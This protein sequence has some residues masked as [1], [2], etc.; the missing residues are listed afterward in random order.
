[1][2]DPVLTIVDEMSN[3]IDAAY[4]VAVAVE[5]LKQRGHSPRA[6]TGIEKLAFDV[7]TRLEDLRD[8][9]DAIR[10]GKEDEPEAPATLG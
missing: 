6:I 7:G 1:M 3:E 9:I 2:T 8:R 5:G 10:T 4:A